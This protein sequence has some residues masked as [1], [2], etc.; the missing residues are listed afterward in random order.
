MHN[1]LMEPSLGTMSR[2]PLHD[3]SAD[4]LFRRCRERQRSLIC[5]AQ[6]LVLREVMQLKGWRTGDLSRASG[7]SRAMIQAIL[8]VEKFPTVDC[9]SRLA[10]AMGMTLFELDLMAKIELDRAMPL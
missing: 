5:A 4:E 7:V 9:L 8:L 1:T 6:V 2:R 10:E 3:L